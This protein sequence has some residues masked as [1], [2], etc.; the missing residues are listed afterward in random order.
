M[1]AETHPLPPLGVRRALLLQG[2]AGPFMRRFAG[3]LLAAGVEVTKVNFHAGDVL[4]FPPTTPGVEVRAFREPFEQWPRWLRALADE[5]GIDGVFLFGD[6]RP[7]HARAI[8][9]IEG[10][11]GKAWVFEEGYLRPD[12]ITL[13]EHGVNGYSRMPR[14]PDVFRH[15]A[16]GALPAATPVGQSYGRAAWYSTLNAMAFTLLNQGFPHYRH[17]RELNCWKHT[18][19]HVRGYLRKVRFQR[20]ERGMIDRFTGPLAKRYFFV[21]L[22]VHCDFQLRHSPFGSVPEMIEHVVET[23]ARHGAPEDHLVFKHHPMDRP[24]CEYGALFERLRHTSGLRGR[25]H[26][27][28]D[29]HLPTLLKHAK[30]TITINSTVGLQSVHHGTPVKTLGTAVYDMPGLTYSGSLE[31]F[32]HEQPAPDPELYRAFRAWLLHANQCNGNFY[33]RVASQ[34]GTGVRWCPGLGDAPSR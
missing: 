30:G 9:L 31:A 32:L 8:E 26:Y 33:K 19:W 14:D 20:A 11:G 7:L 29:L 24:Y 12:W 22:Q 13:E 2:P 28:H 17:H 16:L 27:C 18:A 5:R 25:L 10:R 21:P 1:A 4:F 3:E 23:F 34:T 6:C 15:A